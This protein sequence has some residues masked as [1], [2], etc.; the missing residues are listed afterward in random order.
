MKIVMSENFAGRLFY[1]GKK[2]KTGSYLMIKIREFAYNNLSSRMQSGHETSMSIN[3]THHLR[4][5]NNC[6]FIE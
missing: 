4:T 3:F 6:S 2:V 1:F 5:F